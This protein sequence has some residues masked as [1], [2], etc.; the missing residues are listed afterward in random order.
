MSKLTK[1]E[2]IERRELLG[3]LSQIGGEVFSK[4]FHGVT[5][6]VVPAVQYSR[7]VYDGTADS[8]STND[9]FVHVAVAICS[10]SDTFKRKR[11]EL[12]ALQRLMNGETIPVSRNGCTLDEI[13]DA[14]ADMVIG[15]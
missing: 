2:K 11:G 9:R 10:E 15:G 3:V 12:I 8:R 7:F 6:V 1:N 13:A 14:V 4:P 5:V